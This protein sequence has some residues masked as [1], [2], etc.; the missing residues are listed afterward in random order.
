MLNRLKAWRKKYQHTSEGLKKFFVRRRLGG[1]KES[2][3]KDRNK[4]RRAW[5]NLRFELDSEG[6]GKPLKG[7]E[8]GIQMIKFSL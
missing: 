4:T 2:E 8:K 6:H 1:V 7:F 3:E 5:Q